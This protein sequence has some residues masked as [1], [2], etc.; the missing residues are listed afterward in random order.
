MTKAKSRLQKKPTKLEPK[1]KN[2]IKLGRY[3]KFLPLLL[4]SVINWTALALIMA[5]ISPTQ[6]QNM[7]IPNLYLPVITLFGLACFFGLAF[8]LLHTRRALIIALAAT[9]LFFFRLQQIEL[10]WQ[11]LSITLMFFGIL[12]ISLTL[13]LSSRKQTASS[14]LLPNA[15]IKPQID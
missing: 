8:L 4:L 2:R 13:L 15:D 12:E 7:F 11:L 3:H 14:I 1:P 6:I 10:S 5:T 9:T